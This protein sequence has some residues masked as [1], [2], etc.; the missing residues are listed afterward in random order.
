MLNIPPQEDGTSGSE[1]ED[2]ID[3]EDPNFVIIEENEDMS[4]EYDEEAISYG[5]VDPPSNSKDSDGVGHMVGSLPGE[6]VEVED[7]NTAPDRTP[8]RDDAIASFTCTESKPIHVVSIHPTTPF[9]FAASGESE[10]VYILQLDNEQREVESLHTLKGH[11]DTVS[12][13]SF[14]PNGEWLASGSLDSTIRLWSTET[15]S[16]TYTLSDLYGEIMTFLWHPTSLF[17]LA[18]ADDAQAAMWNVMKGTLLTYFVGHRGPISSMVWSPNTKKVI[19]GSGDGSISVFNPRTGV[20]ELCL[21]KD[22]SPDAAG[23]T[24]LCFVNDDH[25]VVGCEDGTLHVFSFRS[26]K[27][28]THMEELHDQAIES[29]SVSTTL[30][31]FITSSCDC[32]IIVWN[33]NGF[34]PR[35]VHEIEEGI[36]PAL[37]VDQFL[38]AGCSD[39]SIRV[40]DGRSASLEPLYTFKGHRRMVLSMAATENIIITGSDDGNVK[41]FHLT[42]DLFEET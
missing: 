2:F 7:L 23:I 27:I 13:L 17:F 30:N 9:L 26:G 24:S 3:L 4:F 8:E 5:G 38:L 21:S 22:I 39:G 40:W 28:V 6:D 1:R 41:F 34:V 15:W 36:I 32:K 25:C 10:E 31:L 33:I 20:Q 14:S 18:G 12:L 11:S 19:T 37:W 42:K 16:T 29:V 35:M